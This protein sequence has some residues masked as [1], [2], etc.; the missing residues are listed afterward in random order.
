MSS[1]QDSSSTLYRL[2]F[3]EDIR[4]YESPQIR[5]HLSNERTFL[6]W[7]RTGLAI[8]S[9]GVGIEKLT[10]VKSMSGLLGTLFILL[11]IIIFLYSLFRYFETLLAL[12]K[13]RFE[14]NKKG[15]ISIVFLAFLCSLVALLCV[16]VSWGFRDPNE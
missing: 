13:S 7:L 5:D 12:Q 8:V 14:P 6:A 16:A 9:V 2:L 11:G 15:I 3:V 10:L 1:S 4:V